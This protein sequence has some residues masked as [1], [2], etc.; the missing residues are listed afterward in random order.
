MNSCL[1]YFSFIILIIQIHSNLKSEKRYELLNKLSENIHSENSEQTNF[2]KMKYNIDEIEKLLKNNSFPESYNFLN[3]TNMKAIIK[4]QGKCECGWSHSATTALSYR[5]YKKGIN[6]NLSPQDAISCYKGDCEQNTN[7]DSQLNLVKNG[8]TT[9][10][11]FPFITSE[12]ENIPK[13]P[14]KCINGSEIK[15]YYSQ[16]AFQAKNNDQKNFYD[17][18]LIIIDQLITEGP[19]TAFLNIYEDFYDFALNKTKC[20]NDIY[21]YDEKSVFKKVHA[22]TVIGYGLLNNK[23]YWLVQNSWG[24]IGVIM[25]LL[26][27]NLVN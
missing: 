5:F 8:S 7:I 16:N 3:A 4:D 6:V 1:F 21:I 23:Y 22:E 26:K 12:K 9:E 13:C 18:I 17:L 19:I 15:R 14:S 20:R 2:K 24:M 27:L 11:C 10:E 25:V